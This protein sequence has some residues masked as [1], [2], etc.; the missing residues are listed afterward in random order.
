MGNFA[1]LSRCPGCTTSLTG[2]ANCERCGISFVSPEARDLWATLQRADSLL[3]EM[4]TM[5]SPTVDSASRTAGLPIAPSLPIYRR[6]SWSTGSVILGL[7]AVCL[8][9]AA[10]IFITVA[11]DAVDLLGRT[12]ILVATTAMLGVTARL[13]TLRMLRGSAEA[14]WAVATGLFIL[15]YF[16][17]RDYG[18]A[19]LADLRSSD[20]IVLFG[21][22]LAAAGLMLSR[23]SRK[24][25]GVPLAVP[26]VAA[27][28]GVYAV[29]GSI[30]V[31]DWALSY[32]AVI[33]VIAGLALVAVL[34][35]NG[36]LTSARWAALGPIGAYVIALG[37]ATD[38]ILDVDTIAGM[39]GD[40]RAAPLLVVLAITLALGLSAQRLTQL[41]SDASMVL[42]SGAAFIVTLGVALVLYLPLSDEKPV[43]EQ[44]AFAGFAVI[45]VVLAI[46]VSGPWGNGFRCACLGLVV[47]LAIIVSGWLVDMVAAPI[48]ATLDR[49]VWA[50]P[51]NASFM[52]RSSA[53]PPWLGVATISALGLVFAII[54]L[55]RGFTVGLRNTL[56]GSTAL[57]ALVA[58]CAGIV[59]YECPI[60]ILAFVLVLLAIGLIT[61][62]TG[63]SQR[64][65]GAD[66]AAIAACGCACLVAVPSVVV[67]V[68]VWTIA[69][70]VFGLIAWRGRRVA[71]RVTGMVLASFSG[72]GVVL[73]TCRVA[74]TTDKVTAL[75]VVVA[76]GSAILLAQ[77]G[78]ETDRRARSLEA[79]AAF[80]ALVTLGVGAQFAPAWQSLMWTVVGASW[81]F[82]GLRSTKRRFVAAAGS[83]ALVVAYVLRLAASDVDVVEAYTLPAGVLLLIAGLFAMNRR[84]GLRTRTA[85]MPG[86]MLALGPSLPLVMY[87]DATDLRGLLLGMAAIAVLALGFVR[88]WQ[89]PFVLG[90]GF[91][92]T[93]VAIYLGPY[94]DALPR[95]LLI[96]AVGLGL[97]TAG[98][99]WESRV[100]SARAAVAYVFEMR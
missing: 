58:V 45:P 63:T 64:R 10:V 24:I 16:A 3:N 15:D 74:D 4:R 6:R 32:E 80:A 43:A 79:V 30:D 47:P 7:G 92:A 41:A 85:L 39:W 66:F 33:A 81:V 72:F 55:W 36:L 77:W 37:S 65:S 75:V 67:S 60:V 61:L 93:L 53:A 97:L 87:E 29:C 18:L 26:Q 68:I 23:W 2:A 13:L 99:R 52:L 70:A 46:L 8:I 90:V 54:S 27:V 84:A 11:W 48:A 78:K 34:V 40:L 59:L 95:W 57:V 1:D 100:K 19:G 25:L 56:R 44:L 38:H 76:A 9:V 69:V 35:R 86:L 51:W 22:L 50:Q 49:G 28:C 88:N 83:A 20:A 17:A 14:L 98:I 96:A 12:V 42:V 73:A 5:A 82:V 71:S 91:T 31:A 94:A 62:G 89:A 21:L